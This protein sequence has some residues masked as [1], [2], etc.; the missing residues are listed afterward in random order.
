M[1][2]D[3]GLLK[4]EFSYGDAPQYN[5]TL[6]KVQ[7]IPS[8]C[9]GVDEGGSFVRVVDLKQIDWDKKVLT[10]EVNYAALGFKSTVKLRLGTYRALLEEVFSEKWLIKYEYD[11][12]N[13]ERLGLPAAYSIFGYS[14]S[15][16][17]YDR[18][19]DKHTL[20]DK[21]WGFLRFRSGSGRVFERDTLYFVVIP[22]ER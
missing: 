3:L 11:D 13:P 7:Q 22:E 10:Y 15:T 16:G 18:F 20:Q 12:K 6:L 8:R 19:L 5:P 21:Q 4:E 1:P 2:K 14:S 9:I 17:Q